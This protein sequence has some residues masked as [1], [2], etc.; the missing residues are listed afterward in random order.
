[1]ITFIDVDGSKSKKFSLDNV[2][3][4]DFEAGSTDEFVLPN[5][6]SDI[7]EISAIEIWR[8][9]LLDDNLFLN[10]VFV[11]RVKTGAQYVFPV[12]RWVPKNDRLCIR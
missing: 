1:M 3:H 12:H 8:E 11:K 9:G 10:V 6:G 4:N 7:N 5:L 2:L